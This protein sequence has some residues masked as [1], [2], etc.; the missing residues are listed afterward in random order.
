MSMVFPNMP[1][2]SLF[3]QHS[4]KKNTIPI[5]SQSKTLISFSVIPIPIDYSISIFS[6]TILKIPWLS[7]VPFLTCSLISKRN[8]H[9]IPVPIVGFSSEHASVGFFWLNAAEGWIDVLND[10]LNTKVSE[11]VC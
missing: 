6:N 7:M 3:D 2:H 9:G 8:L 5:F 1:T 10:K 11:R 4:E